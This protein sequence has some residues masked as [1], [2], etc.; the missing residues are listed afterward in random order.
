MYAFWIRRNEN[1]APQEVARREFVCF[2]LRP[3]SSACFP[4][5]LGVTDWLLKYG[6]VRDQVFKI[7]RKTVMKM[8][9]GNYP[10]PLKILDVT[11]AGLEKGID[12]GYPLEAKVSTACQLSFSQ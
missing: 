7:A 6:L 9:K 10:A 3:D 1:Y 8:S 2:R 11:K 5:F 4:P 12:I